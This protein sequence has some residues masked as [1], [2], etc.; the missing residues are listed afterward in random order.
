MLD[1]KSVGSHCVA[2]A[3]KHDEVFRERGN[4]VHQRLSLN[5]S[6]RHPSTP[7]QLRQDLG[8]MLIHR[9]EV[10][11]LPEVGHTGLQR[12]QTATTVTHG[13]LR[14]RMCWESD[15]ACLRG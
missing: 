6:L 12:I 1:T 15:S 8:E 10:G 11:L 3:P 2:G 14:L 4:V 7:R 9:P 5:G 13:G